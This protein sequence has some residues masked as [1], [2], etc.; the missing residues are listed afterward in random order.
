M[1]QELDSEHGLPGSASRDKECRDGVRMKGRIKLW[2]GDDGKQEGSVETLDADG[3]DG[4]A[5]VAYVVPSPE[6]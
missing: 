6:M 1:N 5:G 3:G 4:G 2:Y